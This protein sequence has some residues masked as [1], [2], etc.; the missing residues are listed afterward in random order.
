MRSSNVI[1]NCW[2]CDIFLKENVFVDI[3]LC[4]KITT[5][6]NESKICNLF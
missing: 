2:H 4:D 6:F 3:V 1:Q 5:G